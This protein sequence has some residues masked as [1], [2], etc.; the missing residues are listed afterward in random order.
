MYGDPDRRIV[1][2]SVCFAGSRIATVLALQRVLLVIG[3][4]LNIDN[5]CSVVPR[6]SSLQ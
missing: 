1:T 4:F 6:L 5:S 2:A 3:A